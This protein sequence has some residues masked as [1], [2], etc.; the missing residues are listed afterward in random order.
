MFH[1]PNDQM[2]FKHD[3]SIQTESGGGHN[4]L[5]S[6]PFA[7]FEFLSGSAIE[8]FAAE[9]LSRTLNGF[10]DPPEQTHQPMHRY[11]LT[12]AAIIRESYGGCGRVSKK[13]KGPRDFSGDRAVLLMVR[14]ITC[15]KN[16]FRISSWPLPKS[17]MRKSALASGPPPRTAFAAMSPLI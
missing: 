14:Q 10:S 3:R 13:E 15:S 4:N 6:Q 11:A 17:P 12:F 7:S 5:T 16:P 8:S 9:I 1:A 2:A